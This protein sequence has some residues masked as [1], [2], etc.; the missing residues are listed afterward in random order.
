MILNSPGQRKLDDTKDVALTRREVF[1][2]GFL[3]MG[4]LV[5]P[6]LF[7]GSAIGAVGD[8]RLIQFPT[9][10][11]LL[12]PFERLHIPMIRMP[13]VIPDGA[14]APIIVEMDHPM[15]PDHYVTN[16]QIIDYQDPLMWKGTFNFTPANGQVYLYSQ[17]RID[18]GKSTVYVV[19]ECNQHGKWFS[20]HHV[21]VAVGG[22]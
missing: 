7:G 10:R 4:A 20:E 12:T 3:G 1:R 21:D 2:A 8:S 11:D 14:N 19:A 6:H 9:D 5:L 15:D 13:D 22:C 17:L 16:V 18:S